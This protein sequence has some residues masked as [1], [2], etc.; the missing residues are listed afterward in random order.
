M[1]EN[2][3]HNWNYKQLLVVW[4]RKQKMH[5]VILNATVP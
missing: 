1:C 3:D 4:E 5:R 2:G